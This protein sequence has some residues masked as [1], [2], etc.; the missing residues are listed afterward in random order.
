M[1]LN[2]GDPDSGEVLVKR[3]CRF[4]DFWQLSATY[5]DPDKG[6]S[7]HKISGDHDRPEADIEMMIEKRR[8]NDPD[9]WVLEINDPKGLYLLE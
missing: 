6:I 9:L 5:F 2:K 7:W 8:K 1:V 4:G 3:R